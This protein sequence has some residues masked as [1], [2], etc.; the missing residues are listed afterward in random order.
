MKPYLSSFTLPGRGDQ[1]DLL[2]QGVNNRTCFKNF[3]PFQIFKDW[4][5]TTFQFSPITIFYGGNGSG[6]TTLLNLIGDKLGLERRSLYNR[7]AFWPLFVD[8]CQIKAGPIPTG[9]AVVTSDDVFDDLLDLR[10]LNDGVDLDRSRLLAAYRDLRQSK[11]QLRSLED[12]D[13]L[14]QVVA[15]QR[16]TASAFVRQEA[17]VNVRGRSNGETAFRYFTDRITEGRLYLLDEPENSLSAQLQGELAQFLE[18]S[19]RFFRCQLILSTHSPFLLA[20][21]GATVYDLDSRPIRPRPWQDLPAVRTWHAFFQAHR[22]E[23]EEG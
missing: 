17:G 23:L 14:K 10:S 16:K 9:S 6:K 15:A 21:K 13:A 22:R 7:A 5:A 12:Y 1:E 18:D 19:A 4:E 2:Q 3:Y 8:N 20:M 11:F